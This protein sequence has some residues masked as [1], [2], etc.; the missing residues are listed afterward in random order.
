MELMTLDALLPPCCSRSC[1][2]SSDARDDVI[3]ERVTWLLTRKG[4]Q[5]NRWSSSHVFHTRTDTWFTSVSR[6]GIKSSSFLSFRLSRKKRDLMFSFPPCLL[7]LLSV[8]CM[9]GFSLSLRLS[10]DETRIWCIGNITRTEGNPFAF[11]LPLHVSLLVH[12]GK[13]FSHPYLDCHP[14]LTA[15]LWRQTQAT[16]S[17]A[18]HRAMKNPLLLCV[19]I[20]LSLKSLDEIYNWQS[21]FETF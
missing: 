1:H 8:I 11:P 14:F 6:L 9:S 20:L 19:I 21:S 15:A 3:I 10:K 13:R 16:L 7:F 17:I 2:V 18:N 4:K 12:V 5:K